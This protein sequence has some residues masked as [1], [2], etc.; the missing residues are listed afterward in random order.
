[1][2]WPVARML[3]PARRT[4][5]PAAFTS[6]SFTSTARR[7]KISVMI[8]FCSSSAPAY[9]RSRAAPAAS[10]PLRSSSRVLVR[11]PR[12]RISKNARENYPRYSVFMETIHSRST[13]SDS[14]P[15]WERWPRWTKWGPSTHQDRGSC[16]M[17][18][19]A[20]LS[21]TS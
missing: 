4:L 11:P 3:S 2:A 18:D 14:W 7:R 1:M 13:P 21:T 10:P 5:A 20:V 9:S 19:R 17:M 8:F 12:L 6:S 15:S 16:C